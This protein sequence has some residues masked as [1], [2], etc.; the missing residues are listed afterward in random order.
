[1]TKPSDT[2]WGHPARHYASA[3]A[4]SGGG[5]AAPPRGSQ[6]SSIF[7]GR[8][9]TVLDQ[10]Y[11]RLRETVE[12]C[13]KQWNNILRDYM[14]TETGL[15]LTVG[16]ES[17]SVP[18]RVVDGM[19]KPFA[20]V[21]RQFEGLEWAMLNRPALIAARDGTTFMADH[22]G[23]ARG[24]WGPVAGPASIEEINRVRETATAWL[25]ALDDAKA[26]DAIVGIEEDVLGAYFFRRPE[27]Q[28]Y[29]VVIGIIAAALGVSP[30]SLAI[31]TLTHELGHAYTHLGRDIDDERWDTLAFAGTHLNIVEG[32][33]Q[34]YTQVICTRLEPR[35]P[36]ALAAYK[37]LLTK[38]SGPY[39]A[40]LAWV[41]DQERGGEIV[42]VS[43]IECRSRKLKQATEF[44]AAVERH[45]SGVKGRP[46]PK[47]EMKTGA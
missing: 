10:T 40:H 12:R 27:I 13:C 35:M 21:V 34:F 15:R 32:L 42:R 43:M 7:A 46:K 16:D 6:E 45:R 24:M 19:P 14:R 25:K 28:L 3:A 39:K 37:S 9:E 23:K 33:A 44:D 11:P 29:W 4:H 31:V 8:W 17:Q 5:K 38:Q 2:S 47:G 1:M 20:Q 36:A 18:V 22:H 26:V 41:G 30:E